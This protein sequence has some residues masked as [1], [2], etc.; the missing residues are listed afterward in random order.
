MLH[1]QKIDPCFFLNKENVVWAVEL[2]FPALLSFAD[3]KVVRETN[4]DEERS[5]ETGREGGDSPLRPRGMNPTFNS[6]SGANMA[7][8]SNALAA[9][10]YISG[11]STFREIVSCFRKYESSSTV[12]QWGQGWFL[13]LMISIN[14]RLLLGQW[15]WWPWGAGLCTCGWYAVIWLKVPVSQNWKEI[16][17]A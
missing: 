8:I 7:F 6:T 5:S 11:G 1:L 2:N 13:T 10:T 17:K 14:R 16:W 9:Y 15:Y 12:V 4:P 3:K